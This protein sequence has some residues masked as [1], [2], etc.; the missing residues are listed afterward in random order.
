MQAVNTQ[1]D[2]SKGD[3]VMRLGKTPMCIGRRC[4]RLQG[5]LLPVGL[6]NKLTFP[7]DFLSSKGP[8]L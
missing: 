6:R 8:N 4:I 3:I 7:G 2:V 5:L 1:H